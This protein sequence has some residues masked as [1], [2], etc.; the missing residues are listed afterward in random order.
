M[1][2][3]QSLIDAFNRGSFSDAAI[4]ARKGA[5]VKGAEGLSAVAGAQ[6][7]ASQFTA[8]GMEMVQDNIR[9]ANQLLEFGGSDAIVTINK[10]LRTFQT[11]MGELTST[12]VEPTI[13]EMKKLAGVINGSA[14][15]VGAF[16]TAVKE[17]LIDLS[18]ENGNGS[19]SPPAEAVE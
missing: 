9:F 6:G 1:T 16:A 19:P 15:A 3:N 13:R 8:T 12:A 18:G 14:E 4:A 10:T 2:V 5:G 17:G 11:T 7:T